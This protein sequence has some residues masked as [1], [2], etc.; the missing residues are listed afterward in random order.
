MNGK[1]VIA[2]LSVL[3]GLASARAADEDICAKL[4][5]FKEI[6]ESRFKRDSRDLT[7][8]ENWETAVFGGPLLKFEQLKS[9]VDSL[10]IPLDLKQKLRTMLPR[11]QA[12]LARLLRPLTGTEIE[13]AFAIAMIEFG[14]DNLL[15]FDESAN[16]TY[17]V[18]WAKHQKK[19]NIL[20]TLDGETANTQ[21][22]W[23]LAPYIY[24]HLLARSLPQDLCIERLIDWAAENKIEM[25]E[26]ATLPGIY[27]FYRGYGVSQYYLAL[28]DANDITH[29]FSN[30]EAKKLVE[31]EPFFLVR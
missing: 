22:W 8:E 28:H 15:R 2:L 12:H 29:R 11:T 24:K 19:R 16:D 26:R 25:G 23:T 6:R 31:T 1:I 9:A 14:P 5:T 21:V 20:D 27:E 4:I 13:K 30:Q 18:Y 3:F 7:R 10:N 17:T